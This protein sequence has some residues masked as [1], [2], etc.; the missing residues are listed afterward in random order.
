MD[1][2]RKIELHIP[3]VPGYEKV[4]MEA[5]AS[6]ARQMGFSDD[7]IEDLKTAVAEACINAMEHGNKL[8]ASIQVGVT[9]TVKESELQID[10]ADRGKGIGDVEAPEI[11]KKIE[12]E[13]KT[14]GW[15]MFLIRNLMN[16]VQIESG[17]EGGNVVRMFIH[18]DK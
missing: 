6:V 16:E 11:E 4:A 5:A 10:V 17:H 7:R 2:D 1:D 12:G 13:G 14:R 15:G 9:L 8:D 18:L 3:S